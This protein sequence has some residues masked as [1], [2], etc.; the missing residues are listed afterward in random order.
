MAY[1]L[2]SRGNKKRTAAT[3]NGLHSVFKGKQEKNS[4]NSEWLT[5]FLRGIK[6]RTAANDQLTLCFWR[7]NK[8]RTAATVNGLH[9][10]FKGKQEK[11]SCNSEWRTLRFQGETRKE[12]LQQWLAYTL[13]NC[14]GEK[15]RPRHWPGNHP[16]GNHFSWRPAETLFLL[17]TY[18]THTH[19]LS[20][21]AKYG[22]KQAHRS[23]CSHT[24]PHSYSTLMPRLGCCNQDPLF[25]QLV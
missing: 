6:R 23:S 25:L 3:V 20:L 10:V 17:V 5:L 18:T 21:T 1:T 24:T 8:K 7:G 13:T 15:Y 22:F 11:N 12:Q 9:S 4:C 19:A 2:F 14:E 16:P